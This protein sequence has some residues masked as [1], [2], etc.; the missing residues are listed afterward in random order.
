[1]VPATA[2]GN[3]SMKRNLALLASAAMLAGVIAANAQQSPPS[4]GGSTANQCWD[5]STNSIKNQAPGSMASSGTSSSGTSSSSG[6]VG[7]SP[8][9]SAGSTAGS[10]GSS[11][12][13]P[14]TGTSA[15]TRPAGMLSC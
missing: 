10:A 6:T 9:G 2:N 5:V 3:L 7:S 12:S 15:A 1:M 14:S 13:S 8:S 4:P 11:G